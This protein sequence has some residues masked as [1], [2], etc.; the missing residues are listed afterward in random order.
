MGYYVPKP[1]KT[2]A[3]KEMARLQREYNK[4]AKKAGSKTRLKPPGTPA[5]TRRPYRK[6]SH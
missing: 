2:Q 6:K 4:L 5:K 3:Q 1:K